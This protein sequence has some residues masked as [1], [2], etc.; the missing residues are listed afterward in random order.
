M[1]LAKTLTIYPPQSTAGTVIRAT[2]VDVTHRMSEPG[3]LTA[4]IDYRYSTYA[5][6]TTV[7]NPIQRRAYVTY[8][9]GSQVRF[10]G[11][12]T[13]IRR[14]ERNGEPYIEITATDKL[15]VL[16]E[17]LALYGTDA[18]WSRYTPALAQTNAVL[19]QAPVIDNRY[20]YYPDPDT[21]TTAWLS[22][23]APGLPATTLGANITNSSPATG[24]QLKCATTHGGMPPSGFISIAAGTEYIHYDGYNYN[25]ADGYWYA[26]NIT[27]GALDTTAASA[28]AGDAVYAR[29]CKRIHFSTFVLV[30][31]YTGS[32]YEIIQQGNYKIQYED[33]SFAFS[34]D[35]TTLRA[36]A[37][38]YSSLRGNYAVY[39][40]E[41][42]GVL[43]FSAVAEDILETDPSYGGVGFSASYTDTCRPDVV[44]SPE[45][46]LP[47]VTVPKPMY[48][49]DVLRGILTD[50]QLLKGGTND[51]VGLWYDAHNDKLCIKSLA[52]GASTRHYT[53]FTGM[54][55]E[56]NT[57]DLYSSVH[58][59]YEYGGD[60]NLAATSRF[61]H[62]ATSAAPGGAVPYVYQ[63][64]K[65]TWQASAV[66]LFYPAV[67]NCTQNTTLA[68]EGPVNLLTSNDSNNGIALV[69]DAAA[70]ADKYFYAYFPG[71]PDTYFVDTVEVVFDVVGES[72]SAG[73]PEFSATIYGYTSYTA[74]NPPTVS[75]EVS[76]SQALT[77]HLT[78]GTAAD[79]PEYRA[80]SVKAENL[81]V[82]CKAIGIKI[83]NPKK[84]TTGPTGKYGFAIMEIRVNGTRYQQSQ[85][86]LAGSYIA[87]QTDN[88]VAPNSR[89]ALVSAKQGQHKLGL[90]EIG[91][92]SREVARNL[93]WLQLLQSLALAQTRNYTIA[94]APIETQGVPE[95]G[96]TIDMGDGFTGLVNYVHETSDADNVTVDVQLTNYNTTLLGAGV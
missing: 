75:G 84:F 47:R 30:E 67:Y 25:Q 42:A 89:A 61:W 85:I 62:L 45:I 95:L 19:K 93:A 87:G 82:P 16:Q 69:W 8:Q 48:A 51:L 43:N 65:G 31:G 22:T 77:C 78:P 96:D 6:E 92:A 52:Q 59:Q 81:F 39:D 88:I 28:T 55:A 34:Q 14:V 38:P 76:L 63:K 46:V 35:A 4:L 58:A 18:I 49:Y 90:L 29:I 79:T 72:A 12:I 21:A 60:F 24:S 10:R 36:N 53:K 91:P 40:E 57:T 5:S 56:L 73:D 7:T 23:A 20:V 1:G 2:S 37:S 50:L 86:K 64:V 83:N 17:T 74:G 70:A 41:G 54:E 13:D 44:I 3:V 9:L 33:G 66:S 32:A 11:S 94:G 68:G 71:D 27:R 26:Q 80:F 15:G